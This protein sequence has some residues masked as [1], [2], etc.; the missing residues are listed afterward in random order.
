MDTTTLLTRPL[1]TRLGRS[2][3]LP[4]LALGLLAACG[5]E[6]V[7]RDETSTGSAPSAEPAATPTAVPAA[8]GLVE[9]ATPPAT[10]LDDGDGPVLCLGPMTLAYPPTSCSGV[11][12]AG[13]DWADEGAGHQAEGDV[14]WGSYVVTGRWDG[15]TFTVETA[16]PAGKAVQP[17]SPAPGLVKPPVTLAQAELKQI[18]SALQDQPWVLGSAVTGGQVRVDVTYDDG[19]LQEWADEEY[20]EG[21]VVV[22]GQLVDAS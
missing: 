4:L 17:P 22:T 9:P 19:S 16:E 7:A 12:V 18:R 13:W 5:G 20:G 2:L 11:P 14:R 15:E 10:V 21:A 6:D 1:L 8:P 3:A